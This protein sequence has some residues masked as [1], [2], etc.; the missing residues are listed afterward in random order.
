MPYYA[1]TCQR[2]GATI[3]LFRKLSERDAD[4]TCSNCGGKL[5][6]VF[7]QPAVIYRAGGFY[8]KDHREENDNE[9]D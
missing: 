8:S 9:R 4:A 7:R 6:R 2:C 3:E 5:R 1:Y